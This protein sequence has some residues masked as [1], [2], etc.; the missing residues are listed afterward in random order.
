MKTP[1]S[2][3]YFTRQAWP[4]WTAFTLFVLW[5]AFFSVAPGQPFLEPVTVAAVLS[6][7]LADLPGHVAGFAMLL[8]LPAA[9]L[10]AM[11]ALKHLGYRLG[12]LAA[13]MILP[14]F[15]LGVGN[16]MRSFPRMIPDT[17]A[18]IVGRQ[19]GEFYADGEALWVT[20]CWW[21]ALCMVIV[22]F[23]ATRLPR[24]AA[25]SVQE[26]KSC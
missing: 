26:P 22:A 2:S 3:S 9:T 8:A 13:G 18:A 11:A 5:A 23:E 10:A 25:A 4:V 1:S 16:V 12:V 14:L 7:G 6:N 21:L 24:G 19:P 20:A 15:V 17:F